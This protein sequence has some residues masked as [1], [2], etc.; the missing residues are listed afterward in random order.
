MILSLIILVPFLV[1]TMWIYFKSSP[2][3]ISRRTI[4]IY[5]LIIVSLSLIACFGVCFYFY[6]TIG[7]SIDRAWWPVL[8]VF[9]S[10]LVFPVIVIAGGLVRN[11]VLFRNTTSE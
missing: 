5:N 1:I 9:G 10:L 8:A 11:F 6:F 3:H 7:Q 2:K 4:N